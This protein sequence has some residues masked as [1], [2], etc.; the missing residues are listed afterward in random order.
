MSGLSSQEKLDIIKGSLTGEVDKPAFLAIQEAE[1]L[2]M[3]EAEEQAKSQAGSEQSI[4]QPEV[5]STGGPV[6]NGPQVPHPS[7]GSA[8]PHLV[9]SASSMDIGFNQANGTSR[10]AT[11]LGTQ[12]TYKK[13]GLFKYYH[14]GEHKKESAN[15]HGYSRSQTKV[16]KGDRPDATSIPLWDQAKGAFQKAAGSYGQAGQSYMQYFGNALLQGTGLVKENESYFDVDEKDL[17]SDELASYKSMLIQNLNKGKKGK[18]DYRDYSNNSAITEA[19]SSEKARLQLKKNAGSTILKDNTF[20][21][22]SNTTK[23]ALHGLTGNAAYTIDDKGNVHVQDNYDFNYSQKNVKKSGTTIGKMWDIF[24]NSKQEGFYQ[25]AHEVGDKV[26]SRLPVD[27][28]LGSATDM[29]L[30]EKEIKSLTKYNANAS[31]IKKVGTWDLIKRATGFKTGGFKYQ[32]GGYKNYELPKQEKVMSYEEMLRRQRF[33]ESSFDH[34][35]VSPKGATGVAQIMPDTLDYAKMKG[36][37]PKSTTMEDVKKFDL[38]EKIQV[39]Y[40]NNLLDRDWIKGTEKVKRAKALIAY[41]WGPG[42]TFKKLTELKKDG[43]D[44]YSDDLS[45]L[46]HFNDES[47]EYVGRILQNKGD[48]G[49]QYKQ[50][51]KN[52][53]PKKMKK[54]G[55]YKS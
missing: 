28:A 7:Q 32:D 18:L 35:A 15:N 52:N 49:A 3:E 25:K 47:K 36:W 44:I 54:G 6:T 48:F 39:N 14:G 26:K 21:G 8:Q 27:I 29:G 12:G 2:L 10:G 16:K 9:N 55:T 41:N 46:S 42:H 13:G 53:I 38:A 34:T 19:G 31:G 20:L 1:Q 45:W 33:Q 30:S 23:E 17:R 50:G 11:T 22:G 37:V 43:V 51:L 5:A 24:S 4:E 40:M